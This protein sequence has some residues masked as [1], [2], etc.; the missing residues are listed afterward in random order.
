MAAMPKAELTLMENIEDR[1]AQE[2][3]LQKIE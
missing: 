1:V 3:G 2:Y